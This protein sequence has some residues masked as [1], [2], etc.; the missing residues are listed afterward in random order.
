MAE[1]AN[2]TALNLPMVDPL[3]S[4]T[5]KYFDLCQEKLGM[6]PNVL[7]AYAFDTDKL[8]A[9]TGMYNNLMLAPSGLSKL[10]REMIAVVVSSINKCFYC[11]VAHGAAVRAMSGDA[12]LGEALVM[13]YRVADLDAR[14]RA[15][16]DFAA[17]MT[18]QSATISESDRDALRQVGFTDHDIWDIAN[19]AGFFNMTNRVA[20][21]TLMRPND[22]YH[23][24][25]R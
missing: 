4:E 15:M 23:A 25:A 17:L 18:S 3:P 14:Q 21:A 6:I 1:T 16:L 20:S 19:V 10:E 8:D 5:Q 13:N 2:S 9:F 24:Q 11:L 7:R 22:E 12:R